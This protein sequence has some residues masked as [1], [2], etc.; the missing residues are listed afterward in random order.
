MMSRGLRAFA[1]T[2]AGTI[3]LAADLSQRPRTLP[4][5]IAVDSNGWRMR[6]IN[7]SNDSVVLRHLERSPNRTLV[8]DHCFYVMI[9]DEVCNM[10]T[11]IPPHSE[12]SWMH[13]P[14]HYTGVVYEERYLLDTAPPKLWKVLL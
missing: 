12:K 3:G 8:S 7:E 4:P 13:N 5:R 6:V 1:L 11:V 9:G 2:M 10:R 14:G